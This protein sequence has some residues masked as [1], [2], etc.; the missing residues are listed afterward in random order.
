MPRLRARQL[1][2]GQIV[3]FKAYETMTVFCGVD[4]SRIKNILLWSE[5]SGVRWITEKWFNSRYSILVYE[6]AAIKKDQDKKVFK[7]LVFSMLQDNLRERETNLENG[8]TMQYVAESIEETVLESEMTKSLFRRAI[9]D[10]RNQYESGMI[11]I[12]QYSFYLFSLGSCFWSCF[13]F[14]LALFL[15]WLLFEIIGYP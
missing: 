15:T 6:D 12:P 8:E 7:G 5:N 1:N 13:S 3:I 11:K 9:I 10:A 2:I 14:I 4:N